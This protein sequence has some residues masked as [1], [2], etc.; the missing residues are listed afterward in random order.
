MLSFLSWLLSI[1]ELN[2]NLNFSKHVVPESCFSL[3]ISPQMLPKICMKRTKLL[4]IAYI[5][6]YHLVPSLLVGFSLLIPGFSCS[7]KMELLGVF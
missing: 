3:L 4:C 7:K 1:S 5:T 2:L 6:I